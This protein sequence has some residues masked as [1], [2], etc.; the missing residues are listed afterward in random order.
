VPK[1]RCGMVPW[2]STEWRRGACPW[3]SAHGSGVD[4]RRLS[5]VI[6]AKTQ[7]VARTDHPCGTGHRRGSGS[8]KEIICDICKNATRGWNRSP[9]WNGPRRGSRSQKE[10]ICDICKNA[11]R[12]S[13]RSPMWNGPLAREWITEG[14]LQ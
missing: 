7:R 12:G 4:R 6:S 11:T 9:M 8:Q 13:N 10:I 3:G 5:S 2:Q 1:V 14:N